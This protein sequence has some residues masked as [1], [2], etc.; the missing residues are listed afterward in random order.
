MRIS[1]LSE[2]SGVPV[3][4]LKYYLREGLL[5]PGESLG[6]TRA[7]Y[8][9]DHL[10]RVRLV[11]ALVDAGVSVAEARRVTEALDDPPRSRHDLL[12]RAQYA[13]PAP[14]AATPVS[15]EVTG[16]L[17]D[18]GWVVGPDSPALHS[19]S[20]AI[21]AARSAGVPLP[22]DALTG[23]ARASEAVAAVDV[24]N[25]PTDDLASAL[26]RVVAGTVLVDPVLAALRRLAQEH[27]S[28]RG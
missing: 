26:H 16:L 15:D 7:D 19:L 24:S 27:V 21:A 17:A 11:R 25:V 4:T 18:L 6:A 12:G 14:H 8:S 9:E 10:R 22:T 3:A 1:E 5:P 23:Y 13:L 28:S 2:A 20:G